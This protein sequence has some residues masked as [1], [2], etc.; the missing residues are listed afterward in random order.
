M[1]DVHCPQCGRLY[2]ADESHL[3]KSI[4]C[5]ECEEIFPLISVERFVPKEQQWP[6]PQVQPSSRG[7]ATDRASTPLT[8]RPP[9]NP[10]SGASILSQWPRL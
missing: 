7:S 8:K 1:V 6:S 2:H 10:F 5:V 4:R 9:R 3:G